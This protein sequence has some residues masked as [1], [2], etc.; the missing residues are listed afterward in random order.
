M[1]LPPRGV[2]AALQ[3]YNRPALAGASPTQLAA[4]PADGKISY[5]FAARDPAL[6]AAAPVLPVPPLSFS[7]ENR[8]G[9]PATRELPQNGSAQGRGLR[10][11]I[12]ARW[13]LCSLGRLGRPVAPLGGVVGEVAGGP[14]S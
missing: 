7:G 2:K 9:Q 14:A 13:R 3:N 4:S 1:I 11:Y 12:F 5:S 6:G 10:L 8:R